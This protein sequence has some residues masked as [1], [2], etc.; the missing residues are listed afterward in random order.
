[1]K[2]Y[3]TYNTFQLSGI[4]NINESLSTHYLVYK[5]INNING[6]HYIG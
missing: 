1:M 4:E 6:K 5:I 3:Q 2:Y